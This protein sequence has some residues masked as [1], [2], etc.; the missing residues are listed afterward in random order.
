VPGTI[1]ASTDTQKGTAGVAGTGAGTVG[2]A[3]QPLGEDMEKAIA[4]LNQSELLDN[5]IVSFLIRSYEA[6]KVKSQK[7]EER[8]VK[9]EETLAEQK[10][11]ID[12]LVSMKQQA[13]AAA[14]AKQGKGAVSKNQGPDQE[15]RRLADLYTQM[16]PEEVGEIAQ[17]LDD[18]T[19][20][21]VFAQ[22]KSKNVAKILSNFDPERVA[23]LNMKMVK[24]NKESDEE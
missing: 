18:G 11:R 13:D 22:M 24:K 9:L 3:Q 4:Q 17:K 23:R 5:K 16:L 14:A 15:I 12:Q 6:E 19:L 8:M 7:N 21:K 10:V 20:V 1:A 2:S